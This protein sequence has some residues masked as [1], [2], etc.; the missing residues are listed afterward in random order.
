M[1]LVHTENRGWV[2]GAGYSSGKKVV[3]SQSEEAELREGRQLTQEPGGQRGATKIGDVAWKDW[4]IRHKIPRTKSL[5]ASCD[6]GKTTV[7][8]TAYM[9]GRLKG[10][11]KERQTTLERE[12]LTKLAE[13]RSC[14]RDELKLVRILLL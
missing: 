7:Y 13:S 6:L 3:K 1:G 11:E 4:G 5:A 9:T 8:I 2:W 14:K 10:R 12:G